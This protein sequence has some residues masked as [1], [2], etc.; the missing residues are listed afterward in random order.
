MHNATNIMKI[1]KIKLQIILRL[2]KRTGKELLSVR[3]YYFNREKGKVHE[4]HSDKIKS[5]SY[6]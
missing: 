5:L 1:N 6:L 3:H 2:I 4:T